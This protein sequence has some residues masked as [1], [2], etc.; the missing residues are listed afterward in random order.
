MAEDRTELVIAN[1]ADEPG[2]AAQLSN[3]HHRVGHRATGGFQAWTA[4]L[5]KR[6]SLLLIDER[7]SPLGQ[8]V[9]LQK[10]VL[11]LHQHINNG[12]ANPHHIQ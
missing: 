10:A 8:P 7:H 12:V 2:A 6:F 9:L 4:G 1:A 11:G 5:V 3:A